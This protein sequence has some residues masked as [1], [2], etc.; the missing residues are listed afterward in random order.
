MDLGRNLEET[1]EPVAAC[2]EKM[3][4][5]I[6]KYLEPINEGLHELNRNLE[7]KEEKRPH[8]GSKRR[9]VA[10]DMALSPKHLPENIWIM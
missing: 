5:D 10:A 7:V 1:F 2:N 8:I 4:L 6:F 9:W 3:A